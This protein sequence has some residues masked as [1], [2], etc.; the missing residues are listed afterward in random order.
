MSR[1]RKS[2]KMFREVWNP[3][4]EEVVRWAFTP[5]V[6]APD[7]DFELA[8]VHAPELHNLILQCATDEACPQRFFFLSCLYVLVGDA[9]R[10]KWKM[11]PRATITNLIKK[12][13]QAQATDV[14][15]WAER[16]KQLIVEPTTYNYDQWGLDSSFVYEARQQGI[17]KK[18]KRAS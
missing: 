5:N 6:Y 2:K 11:F 3:T 18:K 14:K 8:V 9:V 12:G 16:A 13:Q 10:S 17:K 4:R 7:Q 15:K 1:K